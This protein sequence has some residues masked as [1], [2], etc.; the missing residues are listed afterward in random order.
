MPGD[1]QK[2]NRRVT[3][4]ELIGYITILAVDLAVLRGLPEPMLPYSA[5]LALPTYFLAIGVLGLLVGGGVFFCIGGR[6]Y[7][8]LGAV[9]GIATLFF[10]FLALAWFVYKSHH[11]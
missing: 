7:F 4:R 3:L 2:S 5:V 10:A 9:V 1:T 8:W 11:N 6:K